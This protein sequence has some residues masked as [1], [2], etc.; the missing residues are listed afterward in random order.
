LFV[1]MPLTVYSRQAPMPRGVPRHSSRLLK[2]FIAGFFHCIKAQSS[3]S[4]CLPDAIDPT[5]RKDVVVDGVT[6]PLG[7]FQLGWQSASMNYDIFRIF[8]AE[9]LGYNVIQS[10]FAVSALPGMWALV[11]C[12]G[13]IYDE[14]QLA[15]LCPLSGN[16]TSTSHLLFEP[17]DFWL[18]N[19]M[20]TLQVEPYKSRAPIRL[21]GESGDL[22]WEGTSATYFPQDVLDTAARD[23]VALNSY[24]A[25]NVSNFNP[26]KYF[27]SLE[28]VNTT[29]FYGNAS[30]CSEFWSAQGDSPSRYYQHYFPEDTEGLET[31]ID[32]HG[33]ERLRGRC[34]DGVW[35]LS[36]GCRSN[37]STCIPW[38][39]T[40]ASG[41]D[42]IWQK[43]I[44]YNMPIAI[45]STM[46]NY[47]ETILNHKIMTYTWSPDATLVGLDL[48]QLLFP[49]NDL[50]LDD[51]HFFVTQ[52]RPVRASKWAH[53]DIEKEAPRVWLSATK[54]NLTKSMMI[55][56]LEYTYGN[57]LTSAEGAC[58]FLRENRAW[59]EGWVTPNTN[60]QEGR[61]LFVNDRGDYECQWCPRATASLEG[62]EPESGATTRYCVECALGHYQDNTQSTECL[63][64]AAGRYTDTNA[65]QVCTDCRQGTYQPNEGSSMCI[66]CPV[67]RST[68]VRGATMLQDCVCEEGTYEPLT[69]VCESS[70]DDCGCTVCMEGLDCK[71]GSRLETWLQKV[72]EGLEIDEDEHPI[73]QVQRGYYSLPSQP[74]SIFRC[75]EEEACPGGDPG[76]CSGGRL[77][78]T[79]SRCPSRSF[80]TQDG[81]CKECEGWELELALVCAVFAT[82]C[83]TLGHVAVNWPTS[84][85][86]QWTMTSVFLAGMGVTTCLTF[87][88]YADLDFEAI[89]PLIDLFQFVKIM[90]FDV[91]VLRAACLTGSDRQVVKY[92]TKLCVVPASFL[93]LSLGA[94][95]LSAIPK[96]RTRAGC[97]CA[98]LQN[99]MGMLFTIFFISVSLMSLEAFRCDSHPNG[100][101]SLT[102]DL[103]VL[104][105][106]SPDHGQLVLLSVL[107]IL[108]YPLPFLTCTAVM[109][110][111]YSSWTRRFGS[112]FVLRSRFLFNRM[113]PENTAFAFWHNVRNFAMTLVPVVAT[114]EYSLQVNLLMAIFLVWLLVQMHANPWRFV[115]LN[116]F[117]AFTSAIQILML[118]NFATLSFNDRGSVDKTLDRR[119]GG[120]RR[121]QQSASPSCGGQLLI[122]S[123]RPFHRGF[124]DNI[125]FGFVF[126]KQQ[127]DIISSYLP[128]IS[129]DAVANALELLY[130]ILAWR[131]SPEESEPLVLTEF[132]R[133]RQRAEAESS[134]K[135]SVSRSPSVVGP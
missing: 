49:V 118:N 123:V 68:R 126:D 91:E 92:S 54:M 78:L 47:V 45:A 87:N 111:N 22:G 106:E 83:L 76:T 59:W 88:I 104:C 122:Q 63:K 62:T 129:L 18:G 124:F 115:V 98:A 128:R 27:T 10:G 100:K 133:I 79:C 61:G 94:L 58:H 6:M 13:A 5:L 23:G 121:P 93:A 112:S 46:H 31:Y 74:E 50:E 53:A 12:Q 39:T 73:P 2:F 33:N 55:E 80:L 29:E 41:L 57:G 43:S 19:T 42:L 120:E 103:S 40:Y 21:G 116:R 17:W 30:R 56:A 69:S 86:S 16:V 51:K 108:A 60:C 35:W 90:A 9:V 85:S 107:A 66:E 119:G 132:N 15:S 70:G 7:I 101:T 82:I 81:H 65:S 131:F 52:F 89:E 84:L 109:T 24:V 72:Q 127:L 110:Y 32:D 102:S 14:V 4:S 71:I 113:G 20:H 117:D 99:S 96:C 38:V 105:W 64:C 28:E 114:N 1:S 77:F 11:G 34:E 3:D 26:S 125:R 75:A 67:G 8:A 36:P 130:K 97:T 135:V 37:P 134:K 95:L 25:Y 44:Y 48:T